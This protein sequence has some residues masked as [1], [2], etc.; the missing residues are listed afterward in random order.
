MS[1]P[2]FSRQLAR[3]MVCECIG[4][5]VG[6]SFALALTDA[7]S[8]LAVV[9]GSLLGQSLGGLIGLR[10]NGVRLSDLRR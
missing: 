10:R 5:A 6:G 3:L 8:T 1:G 2:L 9:A 4:V 7:H